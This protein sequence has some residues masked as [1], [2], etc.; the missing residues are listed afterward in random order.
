MR[1][2]LRS[3]S[4]TLVLAELR[5]VRDVIH[6]FK[7]QARDNGIFLGVGVSSDESPSS[8]SRFRGMRFQITI[9]HCCFARP[10]EVWECSEYDNVA[11]ILSQP[12]LTDIMHVPEKTAVAIFNVICKQLERKAIYPNE[13]MAAANDGGGENMG[14]E[15]IHASCTQQNPSYVRRR[16]FG[17]I[18]WRTCDAGVSEM[19]SDSWDI[20]TYLN[21]GITWHEFMR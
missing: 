4:L 16:C 21:D 3:A 8:E 18:A 20:A 13:I 9:V 11:P 10:Q 15:G 2:E 5:L 14:R 17:H 1:F 6:V 7:R 12:H 19:I